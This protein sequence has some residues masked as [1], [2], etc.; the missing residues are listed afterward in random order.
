MKNIDGYIRS[1]E[2]NGAVLNT[3]NTALKAYKMQKNKFKDLEMI[4]NDLNEI[5]N[6]KNEVKDIKNMLSAILEKINK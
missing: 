2:N 4:K 6:L 1:S 5:N 3:D